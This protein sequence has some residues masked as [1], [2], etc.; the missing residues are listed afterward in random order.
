MKVA[1]Y[2][3]VVP[4]CGLAHV[5]AQFDLAGSGNAVTGGT[6]CV[7]AW[8]SPQGLYLV[9]AVTNSPAWDGARLSV[10]NGFC[11]VFFNL[12][13]NP[14]SPLV[15]APPATG[16]VSTLFLVVSGGDAGYATLVHAPR[17]R[18]AARHQ[19]L[20]LASSSL[21]WPPGSPRSAMSGACRRSFCAT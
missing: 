19:G 4:L 20:F 17:R 15:F 2:L 1:V 21:S 11:G 9:P 3:S 12:S 10:T 7:E 6:G 5:I 18:R 8:H 16:V 13:S 14:T